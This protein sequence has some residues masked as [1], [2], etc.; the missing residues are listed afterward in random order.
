NGYTRM[1]AATE[2]ILDQIAAAESADRLAGLLY[3]G[4]E[5]IDY[6]ASRAEQAVRSVAIQGVD[7]S[8]LSFFCEQ[9]KKRVEIA[10]EERARILGLGKIQPAVSKKNAEA[11]TIVVRRK[12]MGTITLDD[13]PQD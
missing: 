6:S 7:A 4:R 12:R 2:T 5:K 8:G 1:A 10:V 13:L 11:E 9:Q 3:Q